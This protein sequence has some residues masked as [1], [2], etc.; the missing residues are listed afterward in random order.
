[1]QNSWIQPLWDLLDIRPKIMLSDTTTVLVLVF[2]LVGFCQ[3]DPDHDTYLQLD[4]YE[5]QRGGN[6]QQ[7]TTGLHTKKAYTGVTSLVNQFEHFTIFRH[8][9]SIFTTLIRTVFDERSQTFCQSS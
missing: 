6:P 3:N 5:L 7:V 8:H 9:L 1:M 4:V 2:L